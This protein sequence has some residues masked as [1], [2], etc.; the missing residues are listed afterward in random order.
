MGSPTC[1]GNGASANEL[2]YT[3]QM[4]VLPNRSCIRAMMKSVA[5]RATPSSKSSLREA[6]TLLTPWDSGIPLV[7]VGGDG[8]G[9]YLLPDDLTDIASLFSPG[10]SQTWDFERHV[11][12]DYGIAH[13][14]NFN[15]WGEL[16]S[17][18]SFK[19]INAVMLYIERN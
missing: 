12:A 19:F 13:L 14:D 11:A 10:V 16:H 2:K 8:D 4:S 7:R 3:G 15:S 17:L 1:I 18:Y 9:G 5:R 6:L